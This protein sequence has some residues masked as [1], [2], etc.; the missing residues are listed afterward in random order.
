MTIA[1]DDAK[2]RSVLLTAALDHIPFDG[3]SKLAMDRANDALKLPDGTVHRLFPRGVRELL[4]YS[5]SQADLQMLAGLAATDLSTLK[6][7]ERIALAVK[8]RIQA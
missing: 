7:R 1:E 3:W 6:I 2:T 5:S 8:L 4:T